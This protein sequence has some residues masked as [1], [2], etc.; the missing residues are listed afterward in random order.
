MYLCD[1]SGLETYPESMK[2]EVF[3]GS[4]WFTRGWT[5]QK[6]IAP[7]DVIFYDRDWN[8]IGTKSTLQISITAVTG[9]SAEVLLNTTSISSNNRSNVH[10]SLSLAH[11]MSWA[12]GQKTTRTEDVA[13]CL[14]GIL[15][16]NMPILYVEGKNA[17]FR[18]QKEIIQNYI[19]LGYWTSVLA[20]SPDDFYNSSR[21][22]Q[23]NRGLQPVQIRRN[24]YRSPYSITN[25]GLCISLPFIESQAF[26]EA[27][28]DGKYILLILFLEQESTPNEPA[29]WARIGCYLYNRKDRDDDDG[30]VNRETI[31]I[32]AEK[33]NHWIDPILR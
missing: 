24:F 5:L 7:L 13:Y 21:V 3:A 30:L 1:I 15:G 2:G 6:L 27:M 11:K 14:M 32:R 25:L 28:L 26:L 10:S 16:I 23:R 9:I 29:L 4:K 19:C 31:Y 20:R 22:V 8:E 17:F 18:L 33:D 12:S